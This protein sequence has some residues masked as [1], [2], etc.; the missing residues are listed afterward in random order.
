MESEAVAH[1]GEIDGATALVDL[2]GVA[3]AE[4]EEQGRL[5][6]WVREDAVAADGAVRGVGLEAGSRIC[7][8]SRLLPVAPEVEGEESAAHA[9]GTGQ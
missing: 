4:S 7:L 1:G 6:G 3:S 8:W 9:G 2:D 5:A